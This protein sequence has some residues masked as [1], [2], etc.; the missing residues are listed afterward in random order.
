MMN[1]LTAHSLVDDSTELFSLPDIYYQVSEMIHDQRFSL[2]DIGQVISKD[3][4]LSARLLKIVNSSFYGYQARI[5]TISR[6]IVVV[7]IEDLNN[8][9]LATSVVDTFNEIPSDLVD[10]TAFWMRSL[11]CGMICK[12]LAQAGSVL[13]SER[14]FLTGLLHNIGSLVMYCKL[15]GPSL[16]V[17]MA[18]DNDRNKVSG[19]EQEVIGFT[20]AEV[21]SE[22]IRRWGMPESIFEAVACYLEPQMAQVHKLDT[23]LLSIASDLVTAAEQTKSP[24]DVIDQIDED[25]FDIIRLTKSDI[26]AVAEKASVEFSHV[27]ELISPT[28]KYH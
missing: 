20:H 13:H 14:L 26:L 2:E 28:K 12:L 8:L 4:A 3:P 19:L 15:P 21:G 1:F 11:H 16:S 6:A 18:A 23:C 9:V 24:E 25:T 27:F 17:L 10:M 7:G 5:D 22:L